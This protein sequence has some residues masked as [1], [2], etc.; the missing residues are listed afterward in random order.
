MAAAADGRG[1]LRAALRHRDLRLLLAGLAVSKT[2]DW[3]YVVGLQV[4]VFESTRS[5]AWVAAATIL[6]LVPA[7]LF[8]PLGGSLADRFERRRVMI[9]CDLARVGCMLLLALVAWR[10]A[11]PALALVLA[12]LSS[13]AGSP[14]LPAAE[15]TTPSLVPESELAAANSALGVI[16]NV[17]I[18]LGPA[19]GG[20]LLLAGPPALAFA[21]N[22]VSFFGSAAAVALMRTRSRPAEQREVSLF[23]HLAAGLRPLTSSAGAAAICGLVAGAA[24]M[25]G[26]QTVLLVLLSAGRLGSGGQGYGYLLAALGVG[27]AAAALVAGRL[28][29]GDRPGLVL[30]IAVAGQGLPLAALALVHSLVV[31]MVLLVVQ[32]VAGVILDVTGYTALQRAMP[33]RLLARVFGFL[34]VTV[35]AS[36]LAGALVA[37]WLTAAAGLSIA[38]AIPGLVITALA[39][40]LVP[41]TRSITVSGLR[42]FEETRGRYDTF[43]RLP[44]FY[45][46]GRPALELL[47]RESSPVE[48]APGEAVVNEGDAADAL[49]VVEAGELDVSTGKVG[50]ETHLNRLGPGDY[51]GEIGILKGVPRTATVRAVTAV[52]LYRIEAGEFSAAV[53]GSPWL[54]GF[55][56]EGIAARLARGGAGRRRRQRRVEKEAINA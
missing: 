43:A 39:L 23:S 22:A 55:V 25:Y 54:S 2:G 32:G 5:A 38:L 8:A 15:A 31:A 53:G 24:F 13:T 19:L 17:G 50:R 1:T 29:G 30:T 12:F 44:V 49:Y 7:G 11:T 33:E 36:I 40:L 16:D 20:L 35:I 27:G 34:Q 37:S 21:I 18:F 42:R 9:A 51:F 46:V 6:R 14:Y 56:S 28:A 41:L 52:R 4:F 10:G 48:A 26:L 3:L 47:V 45:G